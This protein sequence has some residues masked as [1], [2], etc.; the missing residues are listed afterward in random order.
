M[1]I[2]VARPS[3]RGGCGS[4]T[5]AVNLSWLFSQNHKRKTALVDLDLEFGTVALLLDLE[6]TTGL[7]E[8]L[9]SPTRI[10]GLF[11]E[12]ATAKLTENLS[13]MAT[14]ETLSSDV[15]FKP[16]AVDL[17]FDTLGRAN[18]CIVVDLPRSQLAVR[19]RIFE[20]ATDILLVTE[21][22]LPGLRDAMRILSSIQDAATGVPVTVIANRSGGGQQAMPS[23][24]FQKAL[25]HKIDFMI[26]LEEKAFQQAANN[27][28]PL[29]QSD[30]RGKASKVVQAIAAKLLK[31]KQPKSDKKEKKSWSSMFK[32]G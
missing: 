18:E 25:G 24:D 20:T 3:S 5:L 26:P 27:G 30:P 17:L 23:K 7:R 21:L 8:A 16:E 2:R 28:R 22:S 31:E 14:E 13:V 9:E 6:P 1:R 11:V 19:N 4:S 10:D 15:H 32:K 12:S 29:V